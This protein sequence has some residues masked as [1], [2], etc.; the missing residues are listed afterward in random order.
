MMRTTALRALA[1]ACA[2]LLTSLSAHAAERALFLPGQTAATP[3]GALSLGTNPAGLATAAGWDARLQFAAGGQDGANRGAGWGLFLGTGPLGPVTL[4]LS[5]EHLAP[6]DTGSA[7]ASSWYASQRVGLAASWRISEAFSVGVTSRLT[8]VNRG[9]WESAWELGALWRPASW[10]SVGVRGSS[11]GSDVTGF[12]RTRLGVGVAWRP[13]FGTDR[14]TLAADADWL[15]GT[16]L[17]RGLVSAWVRVLRG[18]DVGLE[19]AAYAADGSLQ[20]PTASE[21]RLTVAMRFGFGHVGVQWGVHVPQHGDGGVTAGL[22]LSG[23]TP[24][25]LQASAPEIVHVQLQGAL[26]EHHDGEGTHLGRLLL[27]LD[28]LVAQPLTRVIVFHAAGLEANWAQIEELRDVIARLR[29][30]GKHVV[31]YAETLGTRALA[32][33]AAC[34]KI[35]VPPVGMIAARGVAADFIGLR[36]TLDRLGVVVEAVRFADHKT[37]PEALTGD[38][39]SAA[40]QAQLEK[41][42][43]RSWSTFTDAVALGRDLTPTGVEALLRAGVAFPADARAAHLIDDVATWDE[44]PGLLRQWRWTQAET[45]PAP[46]H[47]TPKRQVRWGAVPKVA[48]VEIA[49]TIADGRNAGGLGGTTLGGTEMAE[50]IDKAAHVP[51]VRALVA[52]MDSPGGA[53]LGSE[54]MRH[55]LATVGKKLPVVASMGGVAASGGYWTSLGAA[56]VFADK[57]TVTGSIGAFVLKPS[58]AGLWQKIGLHVTPFAAG[59]WGNVTGIH[60]PWTAEERALVSQELGRYYGHFLDLT[61]QRRGLARD[62]VEPLAGGRLWYGDEAQARKLVD[63]TGGFLDAVSFARQEAGIR[64]DE[65]SRVVFVPQRSLVERLRKQLI[66]VLADPTPDATAALL[67]QIRAVAGPWLDAVALEQLSSGPLA[68]VPALPDVQGP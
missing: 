31:F 50:V 38:T 52:R 60:R 34:D 24:P 17:D 7:R 12:N 35:V 16:Q 10:L 39:P 64:Q 4:G 45:M 36:D 43:T 68:L 27:D 5:T 59:P 33:A 67:Q 19:A 18:W 11:L 54:S 58:L 13:W 66:G 29:H 49:G 32:L 57:H 30:E 21:R 44:V 28:A 26:T 51:G 62:V 37:A 56:T 55:A 8:N 63:K 1:V 23:D 15:L 47:P 9:P 41:A 46:Y 2:T 65:E 25:S 40:L 61:A 3:D 42:V 20:T 53:I 14:V 6:D 22:R 48:V